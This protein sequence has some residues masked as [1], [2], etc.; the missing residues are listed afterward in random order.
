[1]PALVLALAALA[2]AALW[3][4][5][6]SLAAR[7]IDDCYERAEWHRALAWIERARRWRLVP[8]AELLDARALALQAL[9]DV[10]GAVAC[11]RAYLAHPTAGS[12]L[13]RANTAVDVLVFAG[14]YGEAL[15]VTA[16]WDDR[17]WRELA[18]G[19]PPIFVIL[20]AN[21]A[22]A[23][24]NLGRWDDALAQLA[25]LDAAAR[26]PVTAAILALQRAWILAHRGDGAAAL[27]LADGID[28][29]ALPVAWRAEA[30][31]TRA[32]ALLA[33]DRV[34]EAGV[35][36]EAGLTAARRASS[37]RNGCFLLARVAARAGDLA[38]ACALFERGARHAYR[39]QGGDSLV[40]WG[41][42]L[43]AQRCAPEARTAWSLA[44]ERDPESAAAAAARDR[45][46]TLPSSAQIVE[47][48]RS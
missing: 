40:L 4:R 39:R 18:A 24:Y 42:L 3:W 13:H 43:A 7:A 34:A 9:G 6:R 29:A 30:H 1:M 17:R 27:R 19:H 12:P 47:P 33:L 10:D 22:E 11:A 26:T 38:R 44:I 16:A 21:L 25:D 15:A 48:A 20:R 5:L 23:L 31:Y 45:T 28:R 36:A 41:D 14:R 2:A 8:R 35:E 37:Q 32:S 46:L